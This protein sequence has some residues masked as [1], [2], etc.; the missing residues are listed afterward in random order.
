M[1]VD[2]SGYIAGYTTYYPDEQAIQ[3]VLNHEVETRLNEQPPKPRPLF[4]DAA[5]DIPPSPDIHIS[6]AA[7]GERRMIDHTPEPDVYMTK[8]QPLKFIV[9]DLWETPLA[10][11][12][13]PENPD[14]GNYDVVARVPAAD[15][16]LLRTL[17]REAFE[18]RFGLRIET[19]TRTVRA[20]FPPT[21]AV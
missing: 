6:R 18:K 10:R 2:Q 5:R 1:V 14:Q 16:E 3:H 12:S 19:E 9:T 11:M 13:L 20:Y 7:K 17:D 21:P 15:G 4:P 8:N